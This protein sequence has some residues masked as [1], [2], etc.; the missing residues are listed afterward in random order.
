MCMCMCAGVE[1]NDLLTASR[2][3]ELTDVEFQQEVLRAAPDLC[4]VPRCENRWVVI[5][6]HLG[7]DGGWATPGLSE[8]MLQCAFNKS[9]HN[10][11]LFLDHNGNRMW[12]IG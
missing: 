5:F 8:K 7:P 2:A 4:G 6:K 10:T 9:V 3:L 12:Q 1:D 11:A